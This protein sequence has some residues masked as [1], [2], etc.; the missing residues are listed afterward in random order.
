MSKPMYVAWN[1]VK[2]SA[3]RSVNDTL[4]CGAI[5]HSGWRNVRDALDTGNGL[6]EQFEALGLNPQVHIHYE[7]GDGSAR[8]CETLRYPRLHQTPGS[9]RYDGNARGC[10]QVT[11]DDDLRPGEDHV[12]LEANDLS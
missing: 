1:R 2:P 5:P 11:L 10:L 6:S 12:G 8:A 3:L 7:P 9:E 4:A